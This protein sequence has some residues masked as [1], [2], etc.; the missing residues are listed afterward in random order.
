MCVDEDDRLAPDAVEVLLREIE[1]GNFDAV[2]P[3]ARLFGGAAGTRQA[4]QPSL[5]LMLQGMYLLPNG[6]IMRRSVFEKAGGYDE[7]ARLIGRDDWEIWIR[8]LALGV[9]VHVIDQI[10]YEWRI[11]DGGIGK[12]GSLEHDVRAAEV[13]CIKYLMEKHSEVYGRYPDIRRV[14]LLRALRMERDWHESKGNRLQAAWR[15]AGL[16]YYERSSASIRRAAKLALGALI[17]QNAVQTVVNW[18]RT[19]GVR[20]NQYLKTQ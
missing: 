17:G 1:V 11:A 16:A 2:C 15:A 20:Q 13:A 3:Q 19:L 18:F 10:L 12:P 8:I 7:N 4:V 5:E 14:L 9:R 6:W